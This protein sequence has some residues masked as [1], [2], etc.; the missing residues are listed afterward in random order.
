MNIQWYPGHMHKAAKD[1]KKLLPQ[2]DLVLEIL[3]A[4]LPYSSQNPML[5]GLSGDKPC[6]KVLNKIDLADPVATHNWQNYLQQE[7]RTQTLATTASRP[8]KIQQISQLCHKII[9][10][11]GSNIKPIKVLVVGI[12]NVGKSTIINILARR[13]IAK[14]GNEPAVTKRQQ[15]IKIA[16]NIILF[17]TPGV[18]WGKVQNP[19][20]GYHL[21]AIGSIKDTA[22]VQSTIAIFIADYLIAHYPQLLKQRYKLQELPENGTDFVAILGKKRGCLLAQNQINSERTG[23]ILIDELR[24]GSIGKI[25][26]ETPHEVAAELANLDLAAER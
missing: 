22:I 5:A 14:T 18:L 8:G 4:R 25:T 16:D 3:D 24:R 13:T 1:I 9:K 20:S 6:I 17:D 26:L 19:N 11:K 7:D 12:P 15:Q 10:N 21:A 23:K 2:I